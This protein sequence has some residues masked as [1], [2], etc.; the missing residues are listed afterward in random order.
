MLSTSSAK[1]GRKLCNGKGVVLRA[2][3]TYVPGVLRA[4]Y[5]CTC[6]LGA[7]PGAMETQNFHSAGTVYDVRKLLCACELCFARGTR[8]MSI[9]LLFFNVLSLS[10][11][12]AFHK[13]M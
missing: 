7:A 12:C 9:S 3:G 5:P 8:A 1:Q 10:W 2:A 6:V 4:M 11:P 13:Q